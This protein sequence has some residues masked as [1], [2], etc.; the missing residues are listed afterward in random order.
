VSSSPF[1]HPQMLI[2][3]LRPDKAFVLHEGYHPI[4]RGRI[5]SIL[6]VEKHMEEA[7]RREEQERALPEGLRS[8]FGIRR[9][10]H[11]K[12][13]KKTNPNNCSI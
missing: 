8:R 7:K 6:N 2:R 10:K 5:L 11:K 3:K 1:F 9:D 13:S 4:G 12:K